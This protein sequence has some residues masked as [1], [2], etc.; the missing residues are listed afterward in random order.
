MT[1]LRRSLLRLAEDWLAIRSLAWQEYTSPTRLPISSRACHLAFQSTAK[2]LDAEPKLIGLPFL[3]LSA[4]PRKRSVTWRG[5]SKS[6]PA[7]SQKITS[8]RSSLSR[9]T[10]CGTKPIHQPSERALSDSPRQPRIYLSN[11]DSNRFPSCDRSVAVPHSMPTSRSRTPS[12]SKFPRRTGPSVLALYIERLS[13]AESALGVNSSA[14][15][16]LKPLAM[17]SPDTNHA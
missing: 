7:R 6:L 5:K 17:T 4:Q 13:A 9:S 2:A 11:A 3:P 16:A 15:S 1:G 8:L 10:N 14:M 12:P